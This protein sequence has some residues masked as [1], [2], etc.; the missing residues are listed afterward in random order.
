MK[1]Y[2]YFKKGQLVPQWLVRQTN[3]DTGGAIPACKFGSFGKVMFDSDTGKSVLWSVKKKPKNQSILKVDEMSGVHIKLGKTTFYVG[4]NYRNR[5]WVS[6]LSHAR[7]YG[8]D[9]RTTTKCL[10]IPEHF[11][12][13]KEQS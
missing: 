3:A 13:A 5:V 12:L 7:R 1:H 8:R 10:P 6:P 11:D 2:F 4:G 9:I